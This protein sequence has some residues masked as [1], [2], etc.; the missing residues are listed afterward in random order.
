MF[1]KFWCAD[2]GPEDYKGAPV[3][4]Q[5]LGRRQD[6]QA[7]AVVAGVVDSILNGK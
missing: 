7:S 2:T 3:G 4:I 5:V 6:D 1:T